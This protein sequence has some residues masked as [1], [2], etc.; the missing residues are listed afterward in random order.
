MVNIETLVSNK[1]NI[2]DINHTDILNKIYFKYIN[3][4]RMIILNNKY[5]R[6]SGFEYFENEWKIFSGDIETSLN[7]LIVKHFLIIP[8]NLEDIIEGKN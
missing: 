2:L 7:R 4:I 1:K 8:Y 3:N 5:I 6:E